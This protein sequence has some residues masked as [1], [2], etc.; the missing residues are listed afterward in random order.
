MKIEEL[1]IENERLL[2][3]HKDQMSNNKEQIKLDLKNKFISNLQKIKSDKINQ[4]TE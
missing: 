1:E 4:L 2:N 3:E